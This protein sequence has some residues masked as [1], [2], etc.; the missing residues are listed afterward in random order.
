MERVSME[1]L[2]APLAVFLCCTL[3]ASAPLGYA[4]QTPAPQNQS[5]GKT[6]Q[7]PAY[8]SNQLRGDE[9][10]LHALNRFTFGPRPGD[11]EAVRSMGLDNWF[12]QQLHPESIH[13]TELNAHLAPFL[14]MQWNTRDLLFRLPSNAVIRQVI[15]GKVAVPESGTLHA[16]YE[17]QIYRI[18]AKQ[19]EQNQKKATGQGKQQLASDGSMM[20][21]EAPKGMATDQNAGMAAGTGSMGSDTSPSA[22]TSFPQMDM[23][24]AEPT[25]AQPAFDPSSIANILAL[26]PQQRV[27]QLA[28]MGPQ[29]FDGF[30]KALR[31]GQRVALN[32]GLTPE[33]I[34]TLGALENPEQQVGEEL[35]AQRLTRDIYSNAQLQEVMTD[36]WLNHFNVYLRK[37]EQMPYYLVSY[38]RDMIRPRALGKFEDLL[39]AVAHS[40]AMLV[41]LDNA[42][43]IGPDSLA[44]ER[45]E[46][47]IGA[48]SRPAEEG[49]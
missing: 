29:E 8:Q 1:A 40:P 2:R 17:N 45:A 4:Q 24:G 25:N 28:A 26:P 19:A 12:D 46:D 10:I 43:S 16:I 14:A 31:P 49:A 41:Y 37:N 15:A 27:A 11:L 47:S 6:M 39:E 34:L 30:I 13:Q 33:L 48:P 5:G 44:A 38:E 7:R 9:R 32:A 22:M 3:C 21:V 20:N 36:F 42:E 18:Q 23:S 35:I